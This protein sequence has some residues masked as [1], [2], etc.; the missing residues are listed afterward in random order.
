MGRATLRVPPSSCNLLSSPHPTLSQRERGT[1]SR[2]G[3]VVAAS[4]GHDAGGLVRNSSRDR[5]GGDRRRCALAC[6]AFNAGLSA[7]VRTSPAHPSIYGEAPGPTPRAG[8]K[9]HRAGRSQSGLYKLRSRPAAARLCAWGVLAGGVVASEHRGIHKG[10][11]DSMM[12]HFTP[13][14]NRSQW[15]QI[16]PF[17]SV[18]FRLVP[19]GSA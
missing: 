2:P 9:P 8:E 13:V 3:A 16:V 12:P 11:A 6:Y 19:F 14:P 10:V 17:R 18:S 5:R 15:F 4:S 1:E 7:P